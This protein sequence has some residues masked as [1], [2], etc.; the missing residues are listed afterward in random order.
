MDSGNRVEVVAQGPRRRPASAVRVALCHAHHHK[1][2]QWHRNSYGP[3]NASSM[4]IRTPPRPSP[5][6][7][8]EDHRK[9]GTGRGDACAARFLLEIS[10]E[11]PVRS[12]SS[13]EALAEGDT[14]ESLFPGKFYSSSE[15]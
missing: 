2:H 12:I 11:M 10:R 7:E 14:A 9:V 4:T 8:S 15:G 1:E 3:R 6:S 13:F 5:H